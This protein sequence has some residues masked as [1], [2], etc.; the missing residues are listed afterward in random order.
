MSGVTIFLIVFFI[1][2]GLSYLGLI[3]SVDQLRKSRK[4]W[5]SEAEDYK[6]ISEGLIK[7]EK[8]TAKEKK[9]PI[10]DRVNIFNK[11]N[12]GLRNRGSKKE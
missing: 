1:L 8:E 3:V 5:K 9:K 10:I 2:L 7:N 6:N 4:Y 12:G 11:R